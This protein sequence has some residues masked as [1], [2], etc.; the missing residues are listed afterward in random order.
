MSWPPIQSVGSVKY[1]RAAGSQSRQGGRAAPQPAPH[2]HDIRRDLASGQRSAVP[3]APSLLAPPATR[4]ALAT[5]LEKLSAPHDRGVSLGSGSF[6]EDNFSGK[7][8]I[9]AREKRK[10][11]ESQGLVA[12]W[13]TRRS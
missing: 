5:S 10:V 8:T 11:V 9:A 4:S 12:E 2:D 7:G 1:D 6:N 13:Q 3:T